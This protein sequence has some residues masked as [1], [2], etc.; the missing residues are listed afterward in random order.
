[1]RLLEALKEKFKQIPTT[2]NENGCWIFPLGKKHFYG[3]LTLRQ[4]GE[5]LGMYAHRLAYLV[6]HNDLPDDMHVCHT[7]DNPRCVNPEHLFLGTDADNH[8][9]KVMKGRQPR[10]TKCSQHILTEENVIKIKTGQIRVSDENAKRLGLKSKQY[11]YNI[12]NGKTWRHVLPAAGRAPKNNVKGETSHNAK[13][14]ED[15]IR[16]IRHSREPGSALA[17]HY[18][19]A[20]TTI[21]HIRKRRTWAHIK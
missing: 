4:D 1:M 13:L 18:G 16:A 17:K 6:A 11:M 3:Y 8:A 12:L 2:K 19:V 7:C 5:R 10:G 15:D 9:D 21:I 14:T 20:H